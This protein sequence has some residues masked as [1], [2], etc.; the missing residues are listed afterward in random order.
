[1]LKLKAL[2]ITIASLMMISC[3][4]GTQPPQV[5]IKHSK[6]NIEQAYLINCEPLPVLENKKLSS[7][8]INYIKAAKIYHQCKLRHEAITNAIEQHNNQ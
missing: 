8:L 3:A 1:M 7:A 4:S 6:V 2:A 5:V